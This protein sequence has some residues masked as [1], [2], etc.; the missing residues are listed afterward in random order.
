MINSAQSSGPAEQLRR[1]GRTADLLRALLTEQPGYRRHWRAHVVRSGESEP[2]QGAVARVIAHH[3]W[4][5]GEVD[6]STEDLPRKLKDIV[7]RGLSGR[8]IS[9]QSLQWFIRSFE[10]TEPHE[11]TLWGAL[12]EDLAE[13]ADSPRQVSA[14]PPLPAV[15]QAESDLRANYRTQSL[16]ETY[17]VGPDRCRREHRLVHVLQ[18]V[19]DL[20]HVSYRF[21]TSEV[22]VVVLR[23]GSAGAPVPDR[24]PGRYVLDIQLV[25]PVRAGG[26]TALETQATYPAGG[27]RATHFVRS[28]RASSGGVSLRVQFDP[29]ATPTSVRWRHRGR[30]EVVTTVV[31]LDD[32][33]AVHH[34]LTPTEDC[35]VGFEWD[36]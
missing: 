7:A 30:H 2:H 26:L 11:T 13:Q 15:S 33:Q 32:E 16:I 24:T 10:M 35:V 9:H 3:L 21:D 4:D 12:Q 27:P 22:Q 14:V 36:W 5:T 18:A 34:F 23:G 20:D 28:L 29:A 8:G 19:R 6:E 25:E 1:A 17:S 31:E